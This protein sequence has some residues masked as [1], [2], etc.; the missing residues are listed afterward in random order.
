[1]EYYPDEANSKDLSIVH[2]KNNTDTAFDH[3]T[4]GLIQKLLSDSLQHVDSNIKIYLKDN[5]AYYNLRASK[6]ITTVNSGDINDRFEIVF[7]EDT[8]LSTN[9]SFDTLNTDLNIFFENTINTLFI[10]NPKKHL[11][12]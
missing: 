9:S 5:E 6:Y 2:L 3:G 4:L 7:H 11:V 1:M 10:T 12:E 8:S